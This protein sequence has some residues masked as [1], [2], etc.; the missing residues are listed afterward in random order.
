MT[1]MLPS[2][3]GLGRQKEHGIGRHGLKK[4]AGRSSEEWEGV[5]L[6]DVRVFGKQ[7]PGSYPESV[8]V[9]GTIKTGSCRGK[10][11]VGWE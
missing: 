10:E 1:S 6:D 3:R 4:I 5:I 9:F 2:V 11:E 8:I 7:R